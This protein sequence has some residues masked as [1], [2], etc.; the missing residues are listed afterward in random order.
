[1]KITKEL[2]YMFVC[3]KNIDIKRN[4][5]IKLFNYLKRKKLKINSSK[6]G[7]GKIYLYDCNDFVN[8]SKLYL[9]DNIYG[10]L[11]KIRKTICK[12]IQQIYQFQKMKF[13]NDKVTAELSYKYL[14]KRDYI[15]G[16]VVDGMLKCCEKLLPDIK[17][18]NFKIVEA[19]INSKINFNTKAIAYFQKNARRKKIRLQF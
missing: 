3:Y 16:V 6:L 18:N 11:D 4:L 19:K 2:F 8:K 10:W 12:I 5:N 9:R 17:K 13:S 14:E 1:M 7:E 15:Q